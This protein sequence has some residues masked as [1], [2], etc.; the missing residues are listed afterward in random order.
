[1]MCCAGRGPMVKVSE[2]DRTRK[3]GF[4]LTF[5][6]HFLTHRAV[7]QDACRSNVLLLSS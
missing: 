2:E 1:M 3:F 6:C 4:A 7:G 5:T